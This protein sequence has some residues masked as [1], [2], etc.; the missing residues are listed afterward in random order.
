MARWLGVNLIQTIWSQCFR[1]VP[2]RFPP[3]NLFERV[4][5]PGDLDAVL[6]LESLTN[7]RLREEVGSLHLIPPDDRFTGPGAGYVMAAFTH[8]NPLGS[9]FSNGS[10]GVYYT[11]LDLDTAI[12][13]TVHH[14]V[15][16]LTYTSEPPQDLDMRVLVAELE[17]EMVD[18]NHAGVTDLLHPTNYGPGQAFALE[19][20]GEGRDGIRY[21]SVRQAGGECA[22]VFRPKCIKNCMQSAHLIYPWD[23]TGIQ[24]DRITK[25]MI[26]GSPGVI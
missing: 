21:E 24:R 4:S 9:R 25:K 20:R 6:Q 2:S 10:Y 1:I 18:G 14:Q 7:P 11:A 15:K 22:A 26:L 5:D 8:P 12:A 16:H 17:G 13:E 23:G 19:V 3:I